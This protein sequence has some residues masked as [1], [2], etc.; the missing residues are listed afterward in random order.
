M[1]ITGTP[2]STGSAFSRI[3]RAQAV[4][5]LHRLALDPERRQKRGHLRLRGAALHDFAHYLGRRFARQ[6]APVDQIPDRFPDHAQHLPRK[7]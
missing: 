5:L 2:A 3:T 1:S 6:V 4:I 7:F